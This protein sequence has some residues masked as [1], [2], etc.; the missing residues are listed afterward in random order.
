MPYRTIPFVDGEFYHIFNRGVAKRDIFNNSRDYSQ[1]I[2]TFFYYQIQSP[3]PKF[4][5]YRQSKTFP[6]DASKKIVD[7]ISYCLMPNHFHLLVKQLQSNGISEFMR[8]FTHSYV[9]YR[10]V[11]YNNQGP[12]FQGVFKAVRVETDEQLIHLS[13]YIH[14]NPLVSFLV[15]D[16]NHYPWSSYTSFIGI[17]QTNLVNKDEILKFFKSPQEYEKFVVDQKEYAQVLELIKHST[18]D[19]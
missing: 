16:L 4:S 19:E 11:K 9:K 18:F 3:K 17:E 2:K 15:E 1:F 8:K 13:R 5:V 14:L 12:I 7:I 6:I 10:N